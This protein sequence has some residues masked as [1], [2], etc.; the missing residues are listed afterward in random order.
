MMWV[1]LAIM[2]LAL[3]VIVER[4]V[5]YLR[6][7]A[8]DADQLAV[9]TAR[10]VTE[11][12]IQQALAALGAEGGPARRLIRRASEVAWEGHN[13]GEIRQAV[14]E[15]ALREMPRYGRRLNYLA[16]LANVATL[17]GLL[18]TIFGLQQSFGSLAIAEAADKSLV[19]AAGISQAMNTTAF[20]LMVA[21][22][23]LAVHARLTSLAERRTEEC[24][25]AV[26]KFLNFFDA[27]DRQ[28][29]G[30]A[31]RAAV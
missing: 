17:A 31:R 13:A 15:L 2:A 24:D 28:R 29:Q 5:F 23:C 25:A 16:M 20:G 11:N 22:P 26:V 7:A 27:R 21:M 30:G 6:T 10:Q 9:R 18:G 12:E 19:L 14:E 3:S 4:F 8:D 1:I